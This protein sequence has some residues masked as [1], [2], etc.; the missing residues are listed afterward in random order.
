MLAQSLVFYSYLGIKSQVSVL[1]RLI[2]TLSFFDASLRILSI[3]LFY[4][5]FLGVCKERDCR[6]S[7]FPFYQDMCLPTL[8]FQETEVK[9]SASA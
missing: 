4:L 7:S 5:V 2:I 1:Q 9:L 6:L 8:L 3:C